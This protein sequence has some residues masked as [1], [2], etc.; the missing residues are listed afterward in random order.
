[1]PATVACTWSSRP[2]IFSPACCAAR[3]KVPVPRPLAERSVI[4]QRHE[5]V[6]F[7]IQRFG[8]GARGVENPLEIVSALALFL[9]RSFG[10]G[11]E[12]GQV[13]QCLGIP[14]AVSR[15]AALAVLYLPSAIAASSFRLRSG[16]AWRGFCP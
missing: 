12:R 16:F 9:R 10:G 4:E 5:A 14:F 13:V 7:D 15:F 2:C 11:A 6:D 1:M 8:R 3:P